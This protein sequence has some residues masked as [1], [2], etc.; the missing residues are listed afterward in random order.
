MFGLKNLR[1]IIIDYFMNLNTTGILTSVLFIIAK[2]AI[3]I[4]IALIIK[5]TG[6]IKNATSQ[7]IIGIQQ[8]K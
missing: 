7:P 1:M 5:V 3:N 6:Q 8:N 2:I 4:I